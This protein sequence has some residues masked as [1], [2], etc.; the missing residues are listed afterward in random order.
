MKK[1]INLENTDK[2]IVR[3]L[4]IAE[5]EIIENN[6][7]NMEYILVEDYEEPSIPN[8]SMSINYP[9]YDKANKKFKWVQIQYQNTVTE[10]LLEIENL[11]SENTELQNELDTAQQNISILLELQADLI[12]GAI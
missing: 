11:K 9:M 8:N 5:P 1:A 3:V 12:G 7:T 6:P 10:E 2:N 4:S